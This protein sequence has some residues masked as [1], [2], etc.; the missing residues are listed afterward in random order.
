MCYDKLQFKCKLHCLKICLLKQLFKQNK[1]Y[2]QTQTIT[3]RLDKANQQ[4][5]QSLWEGI[6]IRGSLVH[7]ARIPMKILHWKLQTRYTE[8]LVTIHIDPVLLLQFLSSYNP[9][10]VNLEGRPCSHGVFYPLWLLYCFWLH[11]FRVS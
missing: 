9:C 5:E 4:K 7:T 6:I 10:L 3:L 2:Y 11:F 1:I 8:N